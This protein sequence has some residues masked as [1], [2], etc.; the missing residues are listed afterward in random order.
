MG[1]PKR[2]WHSHALKG[3]G[4]RSIL[5]SHKHIDPHG[6]WEHGPDEEPGEVYWG[7]FPELSVSGLPSREPNNAAHFTVSAP[8][9]ADQPE[10]QQRQ[11]V[12]L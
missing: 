11:V 8:Y 2:W 3:E 4:I 1:P 12:E 6:H 10:K 9:S 7:A 5:H